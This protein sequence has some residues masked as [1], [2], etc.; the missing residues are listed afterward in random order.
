MATV[1][2]KGKKKIVTNDGSVQIDINSNRILHFDQSK[3]R[4]LIGQKTQTATNDSKVLMS[5]E[6]ENVLNA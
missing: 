1:I 3:Y 5:K 2:S 6:G 4:F